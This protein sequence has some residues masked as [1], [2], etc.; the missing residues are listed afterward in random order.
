MG[1]ATGT[2]A[3]QAVEVG[4]GQSVRRAW[5]VALDPGELVFATLDGGLLVCGLDADAERVAAALSQ[6]YTAPWALTKLT[7]ERSRSGAV[8]DP[9][10]LG[11][12]LRSAAATMTG[13]WAGPWVI[14]HQ[15]VRSPAQIAPSELLVSIE[16]AASGECCSPSGRR[17]VFGRQTLARSPTTNERWSS[18]ARCPALPRKAP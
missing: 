13:R 18:S 3:L 7:A 5:R 4:V 17:V 2:T 11:E 9:D 1:A 16:A 12:W 6:A 14:A 15:V 10:R 8:R